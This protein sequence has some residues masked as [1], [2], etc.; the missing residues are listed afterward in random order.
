MWVVSSRSAVLSLR[1]QLAIQEVEP[2]RLVQD[3][4][5]RSRFACHLLRGWLTPGELA[6]SLGDRATAEAKRAGGGA[7]W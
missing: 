2:V 5:Q 4:D 3:T 7:L 6:R 1:R